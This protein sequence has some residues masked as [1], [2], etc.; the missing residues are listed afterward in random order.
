MASSKNKKN[1]VEVDLKNWLSNAQKVVIVGIG[2]PLRKDDF[3]G[4]EIVRN[5][6]NKVSQSVYL[7]E[8]ETVPESFIEPIIDFK[9]THILIIDAAM[10]NL[11]S[12]SSKLIEPDQMVK[13]P[14]VSTHV[15]PLRIFC[16]YLVKTTD[17]KIALLV[18]QPKDTSF[19]EGLTSKLRETATILTNLLSRFLP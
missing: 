10:L 12:G 1:D 2:N 15:L 4:V 8:C 5:L 13:H 16:E 7:I 3:V 6:Q 9:P 18:I 17:A 19:G 11:T 14:A